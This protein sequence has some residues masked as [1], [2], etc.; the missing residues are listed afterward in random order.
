M[1]VRVPCIKI[2][3]AECDVRFVV[4]TEVTTKNGDKGEYKR[5]LALEE[6]GNWSDTFYFHV[7]ERFPI[8]ETIKV[9]MKLLVKVNTLILAPCSVIFADRH[10]YLLSQI[11]ETAISIG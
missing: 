6:R 11:Y 2:M 4:V 10:L 8:Y 3:N 7:F 9:G 5:I 1:I